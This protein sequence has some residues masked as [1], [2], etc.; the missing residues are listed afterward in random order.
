MIVVRGDDRHVFIFIIEYT[1]FYLLY[2]FLL[3]LLLLLITIAVG[4]TGD[5]RNILNRNTPVNGRDIRKILI[6]I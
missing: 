1:I 2:E 3:L 5:G 4:I 6:N